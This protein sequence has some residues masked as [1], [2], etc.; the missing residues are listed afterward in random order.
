MRR[1]TGKF[2]AITIAATHGRSSAI[3]AI[4]STAYPNQGD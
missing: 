3:P 1:A 4:E 2:A